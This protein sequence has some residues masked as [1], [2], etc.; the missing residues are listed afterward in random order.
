MTKNAEK[1]LEPLE[2]SFFTHSK[3]INPHAFEA[4][5]MVDSIFESATTAGIELTLKAIS[6]LQANAE[7][8]FSQLQAL[9]EADSPS[10]V[11]E[12]QSAFVRRRVDASVEQI[13]ESQALT[14]KVLVDLSNSFKDF[15]KQFLAESKAA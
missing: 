15:F 12:L 9:L 14:S 6:A 1:P 3:A 10:Q 8:N 5:K 4:Q 11:I 13:R 2:N 7:A